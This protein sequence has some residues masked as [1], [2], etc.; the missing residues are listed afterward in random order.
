MT[1]NDPPDDWHERSYGE[2]EAWRRGKRNERAR[3]EAAY[4][5]LEIGQNVKTPDGW[6]GFVSE[7]YPDDGEVYVEAWDQGGTYRASRV[8]PVDD[9]ASGV[10]L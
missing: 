3:D 6:V 8:E 5:E 10:S 1:P 2:K 9:G 4:A 7:K